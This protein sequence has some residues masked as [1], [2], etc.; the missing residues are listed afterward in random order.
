MIIIFCFSDIFIDPE[1][2]LDIKN[3]QKKLEE[4]SLDKWHALGILLTLPE[5]KLK[6]IETNY[7]RDVSR[8]LTE[9]IKY[10]INNCKVEWKVLWE[11]LCKRS[12]AQINLGHEIRD[13]YT[14]KIWRDPRRVSHD[15]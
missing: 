2:N 5:S 7:P 10:W 1:L 11:A 12:V 8:C 3:V 6:E 9:V 13:W 15:K 14:D 4:F